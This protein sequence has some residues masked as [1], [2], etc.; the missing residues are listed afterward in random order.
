MAALIPSS[1]ADSVTSLDNAVR[2]LDLRTY[3]H[4]PHIH[5]QI[6]QIATRILHSS[7][8]N[9]KASLE[10]LSEV[11]SLVCL[12]S[13]KNPA[14]YFF[15]NLIEPIP[16]FLEC[17]AYKAAQIPTFSTYHTICNVLSAVRIDPACAW[18]L[19]P[20]E[21][22]HTLGTSPP[23]N[24]DLFF[25]IV[26]AKP[27][28]TEREGLGNVCF[29]RWAYPHLPFGADL[30]KDVLMGM[31]PLIG[32]QRAQDDA[33]ISFGS[34][35]PLRVHVHKN[36]HGNLMLYSPDNAHFRI[37]TDMPFFACWITAQTDGRA[38]LNK[39]I[40]ITNPRHPLG[41]ALLESTKNCTSLA[42]HMD[43]LRSNVEAYLE[44]EILPIADLAA[45][46]PKA[47]LN[48]EPWIQNRVYGEVWK[49]KGSPMGISA[50]FGKEAFFG[51]NIDPRHFCSPEERAQAI[52]NFASS[53]K[54]LLI[55]S[56]QTLFQTGLQ[57]G[58]LIE[59][60]MKIA[61][62]YQNDEIEAGMKLFDALE[63]NQK[64]QVYKAMWEMHG[65]PL[66]KGPNFGKERFLSGLGQEKAQAIL[67]YAS[68]CKAAEPPSFSFAA[69]YGEIL[70]LPSSSEEKPHINNCQLRDLLYKHVCKRWHVLMDSPEPDSLEEKI[71]WGERHA[72]TDKHL[73]LE[74]LKSATEEYIQLSVP[75]SSRDSLYGAVWEAE[76][77]LRG[78]PETEDSHWGEHHLLDNPERL[79]YALDLFFA[80]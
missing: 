58:P 9:K 41:A 52:R 77:Q 69:L 14:Y 59:S 25:S 63:E 30:K 68:R 76:C 51:E 19:I 38:C 74:A 71:R 57:K 10:K 32:V 7:D 2:R 22:Q 55:G 53:L 61:I 42:K 72:C 56:Q 47:L 27:I 21:I 46:D 11:R 20:P 16:P 28:A 48:L 13:A 67:T 3:P 26:H 12:N 60:L 43:K 78:K 24:T 70:A 65:C 44:R 34:L 36:D 5:L 31:F 45:A 17:P 23:E 64:N 33:R 49:Q 62:A 29:H 50:H 1:T 37:S 54:E 6:S 4:L 15:T 18:D 75:E 35:T 8:P 73:L 40:G 79:Y 80:L 39:T 66:D